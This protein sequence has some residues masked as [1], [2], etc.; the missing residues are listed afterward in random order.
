[1]RAVIY[2]TQT[3][4]MFICRI[5]FFRLHESP[6]YLVHAGRPREALESLQMIAQYNNIDLSLRLKDVEDTA[7][8]GDDGVERGAL[9]SEEP[10]RI[11]NDFSQD[12]EPNATTASNEESRN[13]EQAGPHKDYRAT[14]ESPPRS[15]FRSANGDS[16]PRTSD[17]YVVPPARPRPHPS[18]RPLPTAR[19]SRATLLSY[20]SSIHA[21]GSLVERYIR[22]PLAAWSERVA[23]VLSPEWARTTLL[24]WA[25]WSSM[26]LGKKTELL[27]RIVTDLNGTAY[28]MFNVYLP[29][30]LETGGSNPT[31]PSFQERAARPLTDS[32]WDVVIFTLGGCPGAVIGAYMVESRLGRRM[33]LAGST[34]ATAVFCFAFAN[35]ES[36]LAVRISTVGVSLCATAMYAVLYGWTP[37]IFDTKVR[38]TACGIASA[39]SRM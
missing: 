5:V 36:A 3:L 21:N 18:R 37:E 16:K 9:L 39:L 4:A 33:S 23:M 15:P 14:S 28:T 34:F 1:M 20:R 26:S 38:G 25:A 31:D 12:N 10:E 6:R 2:K 19:N 32:L 30:L 8:E 27:A 22:A 13:E 29:K 17:E 35:V 7:V 24:V 11:R